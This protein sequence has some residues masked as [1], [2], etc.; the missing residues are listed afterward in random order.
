MKPF[1][2]ISKSGIRSI[3]GKMLDYSEKIDYRYSINTDACSNQMKCPFANSYLDLKNQIEQERSK[4][5][6]DLNVI[7]DATQRMKDIASS[8]AAMGCPYSKVERIYTSDK[9]R[10]NLYNKDFANRRLPKSM[11]RTYLLLFSIPQETLGELHFIKNISV[12]V[13]ASVLN[14]CKETARKSLETLAAF[15]YITL[16]HASSH[17]HYNIIIRE[18]DSM[19]L[20]AEKGGTGYFTI[21]SEMMHEI[22][23]INNVNALRLE[24][25]K[26]LKGDDD[27]LKSVNMSEYKIA[28]LKNVMPSHTNY[29]YQYTKLDS[30]PS[31]F[32]TTIIDNRLHFTLKSK[33]NLRICLDD[34]VVSLMDDFKQYTAALGLTLNSFQIENVCDLAREYTVNNIKSSLT[35]ISI[36]FK[37]KFNSILNLGALLRS[38]CRKNFIKI[39]A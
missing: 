23:S 27:S 7:Y 19:H 13:L 37:D 30:Q 20:P 33:Y 15:N 6:P 34:Y 38:Y 29:A 16:S 22:L 21:S 9:K 10:Y 25:L 36:D 8:C 17:G 39:A 14:V 3:I 18:Y 11:I 5:M 35:K 4:K 31:L 32:H 24:I 28:D 26:L 1:I 2:R 12:D